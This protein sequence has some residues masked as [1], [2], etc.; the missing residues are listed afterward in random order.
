[1]LGGLLTAVFFG[2]LA[3]RQLKLDEIGISDGLLFTLW[4]LMIRFVVPP[5][6]LI[7]LVMGITE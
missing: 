5:V 1:L 7:A 6:L 2:W 3:P 4:H